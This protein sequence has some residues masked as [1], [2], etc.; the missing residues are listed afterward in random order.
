M[1]AGN[2]KQATDQMPRTCLVLDGR[3]L[4]GKISLVCMILLVVYIV[5]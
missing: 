1:E 4:D 3:C 5:L 2:G